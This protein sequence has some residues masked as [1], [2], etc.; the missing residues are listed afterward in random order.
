KYS[1]DL[2]LTIVKEYLE[3]PMGFKLLAKKYGIPD[4]GQIRRWV[5]SYKAFGKEGLR[6]KRSK[7]T[8]SVHFKLN[9][10]NFMKNTGNSYQDT[11]I[12][13]KIN[14]P[15]L[16]ANWKKSFL[17]H[18][19]EGLKQKPKGRPPMSRKRKPEQS[20]QVKRMTREEQLEREIELLRLENAYLKKL[21]AFQEK[22]NAYLEK[23][24]QRWHLNSKK[25]DSN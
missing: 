20:K 8:Y 17:N 24:K 16:I 3:G 4:N 11:A 19:I 25:K 9:V 13:F 7:T 1:D 14:N 5:N 23:H 21:N 22:P 10:L 15:S 12:K 18:G 2:K 6:Q